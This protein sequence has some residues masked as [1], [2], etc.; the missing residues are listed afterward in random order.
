MLNNGIIKNPKI[1]ITYLNGK[2]FSVSTF[3]LIVFNKP[4]KIGLI[5]LIIDQNPP[6]SIAPTP[7]NLI[8]VFQ[9]VQAVSTILPSEGYSP[10]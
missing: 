7:K 2:S 10:V 4:L 1:K 5:I 8:F 6:I 9:T 3:V